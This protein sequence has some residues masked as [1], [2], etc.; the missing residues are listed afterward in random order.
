MPNP[1]QDDHPHFGN[2][3]KSAGVIDMDIEPPPL[4]PTSCLSH[5]R[6]CSSIDINSD[7]SE[8]GGGG[9]VSSSKSGGG[10]VSA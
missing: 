10:G 7:N 8:I 5:S 9:G 2:D 1:E 4:V 6:S 3:P